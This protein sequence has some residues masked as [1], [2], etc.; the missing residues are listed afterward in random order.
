[1][2]P[3]NGVDSVTVKAWVQTPSVGVTKCV[4]Q[5]IAKATGM[6]YEGANVRAL[7][8]FLAFCKC[9]DNTICAYFLLVQIPRLLEVTIHEMPER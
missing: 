4:V 1:M 2:A 3:L 7:L 6:V 9:V 8:A 5:K